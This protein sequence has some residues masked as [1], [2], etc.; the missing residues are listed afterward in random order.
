MSLCLFFMR[1]IFYGTRS[2]TYKSGDHKFLVPILFCWHPVT[3]LQ[4]S[5]NLLGKLYKCSLNLIIIAN[6]PLFSD[7]YIN[8]HFFLLL[9]AAIGKVTSVV[10]VN[11]H[12]FF[13]RI[14][15]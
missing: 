6:C 15:L 13:L 3:I 1:F 12:F 5:V 14:L 7:N 2:L 9:L 11:L 8:A 10:L 4:G